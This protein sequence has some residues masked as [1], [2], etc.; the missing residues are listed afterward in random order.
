MLAASFG[1]IY[2]CA[3]MSTSLKTKYPVGSCDSKNAE[4]FKPGTEEV[5]VNKYKDSA[6]DELFDNEVL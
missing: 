2:Y 5:D 6:F 1:I 4:F 3:S